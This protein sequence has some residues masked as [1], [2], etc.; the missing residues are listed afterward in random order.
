MLALTK[1]STEDKELLVADIAFAYDNGD[2]VKLLIKRGDE[3][4][5]GNEL[6]LKALN[7]EI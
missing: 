6:R 4:K 1:R 3:I 5:A 2:L 7:A